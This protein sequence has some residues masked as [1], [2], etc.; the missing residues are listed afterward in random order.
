MALPARSQVRPAADIVHGFLRGTMGFTAADLEA[1]ESG[2][3]VARLMRS[4]D[5]EDVN[6]FGAVRI[7]VSPE[8]FLQQLREID[9]LERKLG[10]A[11]AGKFHDP[12]QLQD[13]DALMLGEQDIAALKECEPTDCTMQL[14]SL[15]MTRFRR[16]VKWDAT[17]APAQAQR[18]FRQLMLEHL[19]AY[20]AGGYGALADYTDRNLPISAAHEF[21]LLSAPGDLPVDLP[22]LMYYLGGYPKVPLQ[23]AS[24]YFYWNKGEFGIKPTV[25]LNHVTIYPTAGLAN[26]GPLRFVAATSQIYADH[27]FSATLELRSVLDDPKAPGRAVYLF[28]T[29]KSRVSGLSGL[30]GV[31]IRPIAKSRARTGMERY[32]LVT[33]KVLEPPVLVPGA[34]GEPGR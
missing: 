18:L 4:R 32:L 17:D 5:P 29:T 26:G 10:I 30:M 2:R 15:D 16:D 24:D 21:R 13:L 8:S 11:Q 22:A 23:G 34:P 9:V 25:R 12:P 28:Y 7:A 6:I 3:A 14:P 20:R 1:L 27:Y 19:Q 33:K 31:F